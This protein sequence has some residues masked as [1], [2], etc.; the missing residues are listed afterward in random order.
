MFRKNNGVLTSLWTY[1]A[2]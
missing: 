1:V 2:P